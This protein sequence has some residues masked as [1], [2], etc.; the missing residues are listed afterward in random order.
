MT[1]APTSGVWANATIKPKERVA[2]PAGVPRHGLTIADDVLEYADSH[3]TPMSPSLAELVNETVERTGPYAVAMCGTVEGTLLKMLASSVGARRILEIGL[4]TGFSA[5]ML[6]EALPDDGEL[7]ACEFNHGF[8]EFAEE[9]FQK[10]AAG[11]KIT[12]LEGAALD[13]LKTVQ[14]PFDIIFIDADKDNYIAYYEIAVPM[15]SPNGIIA[16]DNVLWLGKVSNPDDD[17]SAQVM[18]AFN[19]HVRNDPRVTNVILT[20]RDGLMLVRRK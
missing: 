12:I 14:G 11:R 3:T 2:P 10:S 6:A 13:T 18:D 17:D 16:V 1:K 5:L 7:I 8:I 15:L 4:F 20:V 9:I 19:K